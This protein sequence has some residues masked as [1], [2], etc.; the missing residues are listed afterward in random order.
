MVKLV[1]IGFIGT[2]GIAEAH[3]KRLREIPETQVTAVCDI[4]KERAEA[5]AKPLEAAVFTDWTKLLKEAKLDALFICVP[6]HAHADIEVRAAQKG[7]HLFVEKPVN[8]Y[9]DKALEAWRAIKK[10]GVMT[11]AGYVLRY[12]ASSVQLRKFL[13]DK[14]VGTAHVFRWGGIP[15]APWWS[16]YEQSGGQIVEQTTHQIDL[17]RWVLGDV[18]AV[19]AGYSFK[20]VF[21][22]QPQITIP[23]SQAVLLHFKS[24]AIATVNASCG[25]GK[26]GVSGVDFQIKDA[27]VSWRGDGVKIEPEGGYSLPPPPLETPSIDAAFVRAIASGNAALLYSPYDD[28]LK[29]LAVT[30]A[31]NKSAESGGTLV[32]L[33]ELLPN[34]A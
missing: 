21:K 5:F 26:S 6:P 24:G 10:A 29:S 9:L 11:Q 16:K 33:S 19:S 7:L 32:K 8:L 30:L 20:R 28:A 31:A 14:T 18:E 23:D 4:N 2:G 17:L 25:C 22:D 34:G 1:R 3:V 13:A 12:F 27:K 15:G